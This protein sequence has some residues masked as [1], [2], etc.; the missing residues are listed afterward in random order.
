VGDLNR[1][2]NINL[3]GLGENNWKLNANG[4][5]ELGKQVN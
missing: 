2:S 1:P 3:S 4:P 5:H